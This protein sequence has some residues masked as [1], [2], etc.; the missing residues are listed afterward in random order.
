MAFDGAAV[1][2]SQMNGRGSRHTM[3]GFDHQSVIP[4]YP[5]RNGNN[6][7]FIQLRDCAKFCF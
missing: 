1:P 7:S 6:R 5:L 2:T 3:A 4:I